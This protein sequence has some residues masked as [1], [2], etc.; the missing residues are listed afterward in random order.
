MTYFRSYGTTLTVSF[1]EFISNVPRKFLLNQLY[2][3]SNKLE[4]EEAINKG[5]K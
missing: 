2:M 1:N 5:Y 3:F 4:A